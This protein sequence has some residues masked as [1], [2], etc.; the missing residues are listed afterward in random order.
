MPGAPAATQTRT[1]SST[2]G[3]LPPRELRTVATLLT[4]TERRI[5]RTR[6]TPTCFFHGIDDFLPPPA[7]LGLVLPFEHDAQQRLG[8]GV[9]HEQPAVAGEPRLDRRHD[10]RHR[11]HRLQIDLLLHAQVHQHLRI[12][13]QLRRQ[14]G[15]RRA[16]SP[17]IVRSTFSDVARPS[18]VNR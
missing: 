10:R 7:D 8:A 18:P 5:M 4:L 3:T 17:A 11:G 14:V 12:G 1:A 9:A 2:D 13:R 6:I 16:R 15:E